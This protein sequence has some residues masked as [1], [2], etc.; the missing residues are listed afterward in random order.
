MCCI[1]GLGL[2]PKEGFFGILI[3]FMGIKY[4][5]RIVKVV[6]TDKE[7]YNAHICSSCAKSL[8]KILP[9]VVEE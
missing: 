5:R 9:K 6:H 8:A 3:Q 1:C 4:G 7:E 2:V